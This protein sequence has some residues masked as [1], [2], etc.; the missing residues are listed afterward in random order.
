MTKSRTIRVY[1]KDDLSLQLSVRKA[2]LTDDQLCLW[3]EL[4][5]RRAIN[6]RVA[7]RAICVRETETKKIKPLKEKADQLRRSASKTLAKLQNMDA[8]IA[9]RE[10]ALLGKIRGIG[11]LMDIEEIERKL[12]AS[13]ESK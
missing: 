1:S 7:A 3:L 12:N 5:K 6:R 4:K 11:P 8:D 13:L 9:E 10:S 2:E